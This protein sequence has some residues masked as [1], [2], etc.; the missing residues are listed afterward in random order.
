MRINL[1][2]SW[3]LP[4]LSGIFIGTSYIPFPPWAAVFGFIPLWM[5]WE[6]QTRLK[7]VILGGILS[8][9]V[10]TIIGFNWV[11]HLLH[12]Y[13]QAP[14]FVAVLGMLLFALFAHLFVPLAG[15]LWFVGRKHNFYT[16]WQSILA[17][18]LLTALSLWALPMLFKWNFGYSWYGAKIPVYHLAEYIG[19]SGLSML[20]ILANV[21]LYFAWQ[22]RQDRKGRVILIRVVIV[23]LGLNAFGLSTKAW[24][25]K[26]DASFNTLLVQANIGNA[27]KMAAEFG[28]G[29]YEQIINKY[30]QVTDKGLQEH[31]S[32][33]IDFIM[34]SET[35]F[36]S[37]LNGEYQQTYYAQQLIQYINKRQVAL[38]T[39]AY[40]KDPE[41][42]LITNSLF[43]LD[44]KGQVESRYY[45][46]TIL[47]AFGEYIPGEEQFPIFREWLPMVGHFGRG[48]GPTQL[49]SLEDYKIGAQI[50]YESLYPD[51]SKALADLGAQFIVNVTN[52]SWYGTW[53]EPY[54]HM[55]MTLGRAVETRRPLVRVTNTGISTVVLA[56]GEILQQSPMY[57]EWAGLYSVPYISQPK[58]T[59]YQRNFAL[60]PSLLLG[61]LLLLLLNGY[62][63]SEK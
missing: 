4:V 26:P 7:N 33:D 31:V 53:Q 50:C 18:A 61:I 30:Q 9:F 12:E 15:A 3:L 5:F 27:E 22:K 43:V 2:N 37:L 52:D 54:Q 60:M 1:T 59:F 45:S 55:Y 11:T 47:L 34:W 25:P 14:W 23:F 58:T 16:G 6:Q 24:L 32:V 10:F 41:T 29:F 21:P 51:F 39:G 42:G 28:R 44:K 49:L 17:M 13:A 19:F 20:T 62:R 57:Q 40:A 63:L 8:T 36:P 46:K 56:S 38:L 35:A 48:Q